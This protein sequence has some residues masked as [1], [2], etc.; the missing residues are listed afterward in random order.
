MDRVFETA[1][2]KAPQQNSRSTTAISCDHGHYR[3]KEEEKKRH[4]W[5]NQFSRPVKPAQARA[6]H[7]SPTTLSS[8]GQTNHTDTR[9]NHPTVTP[10]SLTSR[11]TSGHR[12]IEFTAPTQVFVKRR[13]DEAGATRKQPTRT[14]LG[15]HPSYK[16]GRPLPVPKICPRRQKAHNNPGSCPTNGL[17]PCFHGTTSR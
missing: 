10:A 13:A 3:A 7:R 4:F 5:A 17:K 16:N 2:R 9:T 8:N 12:D 1:A 14:I 6:R 15:V 11:P